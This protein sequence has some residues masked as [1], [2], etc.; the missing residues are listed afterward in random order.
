MRSFQENTQS[1]F[2][3][4]YYLLPSRSVSLISI[5]V[6]GKLQIF[7]AKKSENTRPSLKAWPWPQDW[8][9]TLKNGFLS[10]HRARGCVR[11]F[12]W[13]VA[14]PHQAS[15][16]SR[17][18]PGS[19]GETKVEKVHDIRRRDNSWHLT[20]SWQTQIDNSF[21]VLWP[22]CYEKHKPNRPKRAWPESLM[23]NDTIEPFPSSILKGSLV[24]YDRTKSKNS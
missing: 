15:S 21:S 24:M 14:T 7:G 1:W 20:V 5:C 16:G 4:F 10:V 6:G 2:K 22:E 18:A 19:S 17:C 3:T 12:L 9:S 13:T 23:N 8:E 11:L